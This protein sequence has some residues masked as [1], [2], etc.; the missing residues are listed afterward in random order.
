MANGVTEVTLLDPEKPPPQDVLRDLLGGAEFE[1]YI[2]VLDDSDNC[3]LLTPES[4]TSSAVCGDFLDPVAANLE[5]S[6][7][8]PSN[9]LK[10]LEKDGPLI[11]LSSPFQKFVAAETNETDAAKQLQL[12]AN[13]EPSTAKVILNIHGSKCLRYKTK[14]K[15]REN[16]PRFF[17]DSELVFLLVG[18]HLY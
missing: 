17:I 16:I 7:Y 9:Y 4:V 10:A 5:E 8:L 13:V 14:H 11:S 12:S 3:S 1:K 15:Y 2:E 18:L 6:S